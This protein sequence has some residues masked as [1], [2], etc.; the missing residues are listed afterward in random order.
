MLVVVRDSWGLAAP[1][2]INP[3]WRL[4]DQKNLYFLWKIHRQ[5]EGKPY[6]F[7]W[8]NRFKSKKW[9]HTR[10]KFDLQVEYKNPG[11]DVHISKTRK[12]KFQSPPGRNE[13]ASNFGSIL[14]WTHPKM[15]EQSIHSLNLRWMRGFFT[16]TFVTITKYKCYR[17]C[18]KRL[19]PVTPYQP[20][21]LCPSNAHRRSLDGLLAASQERSMA[22]LQN[23]LKR[24]QGP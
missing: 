20:T 15:D 19:L 17:S 3:V 4:D 22:K 18:Q 12:P 24:F 14:V 5:V 11:L 10:Y 8:K 6:F 13:K 2:F 16:F 1:T 23:R 7:H 21:Q 9:V